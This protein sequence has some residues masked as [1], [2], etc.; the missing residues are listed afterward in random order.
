MILYGSRRTQFYQSHTRAENLCG[1]QNTHCA[2]KNKNCEACHTDPVTGIPKFHT[3]SGSPLHDSGYVPN[4]EVNCNQCHANNLKN[5][6]IGRTSSTTNTVID[7]AT[8]HKSGNPAVLLAIS[9]KNNSCDA[10][11]IYPTLKHRPAHAANVFT[12][13]SI[14]SDAGT[15]VT[16][17]KTTNLNELH[18]GK[19]T[20][21]GATM[22]CNTC[23]ASSDTKVVNAIT[24]KQTNSC[25]ACHTVHAPKDATA[26]HNSADVF[27]VQADTDCASCHD[28]NVKAEHIDKGRTVNGVVM[29]CDSCHAVHPQ[30]PAVS[31]HDST[32]LWAT[33][34]D[35]SCSGCHNRNIRSE[36][37]DNPAR[38]TSTGQPINCDTCHAS[39]DPKVVAAITAK[40][41]S[42]DAFFP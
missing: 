6:H 18:V 15:C 38:T 40:N 14:R 34:A 31:Q 24:T 21:T 27:A 16:C 3:T 4:A 10:C 11:H 42:C 25:E 39:T 33:T 9:S 13:D 28:R 17:H 19:L 30:K 5:E 26:V 8:C 32:A 37:L 23:H 1:N 7:C 20:S 35:V 29:T 2:G 22:D 36:H 41:N 12:T